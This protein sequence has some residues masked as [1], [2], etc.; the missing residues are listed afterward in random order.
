[1]TTINESLTL[2]CN[3]EIVETIKTGLKNH[4]NKTYQKLLKD[5]HWYKI[6]HFISYL[7]LKPIIDNRY[8]NRTDFIYIDKIFFEKM[9]VKDFYTDIK[10]ALIEL[11][12]LEVNE[13]YIQGKFT[14]SYRLNPIYT[15]IK[16]QKETIPSSSPVY[17]KQL[18]H[19]RNNLNRTI[20]GNT[21]LNHQVYIKIE[22]QLHR[23]TI[24]ESAAKQYLL[25]S[26]KEQLDNPTSIKR[27]KYMMFEGLDENTRQ[28][29]L[30]DYQNQLNDLFG[31]STNTPR[32][33]P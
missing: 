17:V 3:P 16:F 24:D 28:N 11:G 27:K 15:S 14:K 2:Y 9:Y 19:R 30:M 12:I 26:V 20:Y 7:Y 31:I 32:N 6:L 8:K 13:R 29:I 1:M 21:T 22:E 25:D 10:N 23:L 5:L 18:D 33:I 4:P